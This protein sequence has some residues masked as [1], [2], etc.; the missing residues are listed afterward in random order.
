M[1]IKIQKNSLSLVVRILDRKKK[2]KPCIDVPPQK[3]PFPG[4][5]PESTKLPRSSPEKEGISSAYISQYLRELLEVDGVYP[6]GVIVLRH[7]KV[8]A[9]ASYAPY[10][11]D[12]WATT[13]SLC[14][15]VT[16]L[17]VGL[18]HDDGLLSPDDR[19]ADLLPDEVKKLTPLV[20]AKQSQLTVR[21]LMTMTT[22]V[23]F[24][25]AGSVTETDW[26]HGFLTSMLKTENENKFDY[27]SMNTYMLSAIVCKLYNKS[28]TDLL[29][30]RIFGP[31]GIRRFFWETCPRGYEKGGWGMYMLPEDMAKLGQ[32]FL[33]DG[34]WEGKQLVSADWIEAMRK[35]QITVPKTVGT[36]NYGWQMWNKATPKIWLLNGMF[37]Q[38][39]LA[40][41]DNDIVVAAVAGNN[42]MFQTNAF[43][44]IT[45][46]Y[47]GRA[48]PDEPLRRSVKASAG[49]CETLA[50]LADTESENSMRG[51]VPL[52]AE[53]GA[54]RRG[55]KL[56]R[57]RA[58]EERFC[59]AGKA[60][61]GRYYVTDSPIA[62][63]LG[64]LPLYLQAIQNNYSDGIEQIGFEQHGEQLVLNVREGD[65]TYTLPVPFGETVYTKLSFH[66]EEYEAGVT[67]KLYTDE[68]GYDILGIRIS[69]LEFA[70]ERYIRLRFAGDNIYSDWSETPGVEFLENGFSYY[71][72]VISGDNKIIG[73]LLSRTDAES[74]RTKIRNTVYPK[75]TWKRTEK[76]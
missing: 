72:K 34:A 59:A 39:V 65:V 62:Q 66:G 25:E 17:A 76:A 73:D 37:G 45:E 23:M 42:D 47:F 43:F 20:F 52:S 6:H 36:Y 28:L 49:L 24:N 35:K 69:F 21:R 51:L 30:E 48:F 31:M 54:V 19:I 38:N 15:T 12:V 75:I 13:Y 27:N 71:K 8:I 11:T 4:S 60:L 32:L 68:R 64:L 74:V 63:T 18:A 46:K 26:I 7:G 53:K 61:N 41:P 70:E 33:Q 10:R 55:E 9:E 29:G 44:P 5:L 57:S 2:T 50:L 22:N 16:G 3:A 14:K 67:G 1:D 40:F 58:A 56:S